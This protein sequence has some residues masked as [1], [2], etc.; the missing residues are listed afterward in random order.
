MFFVIVFPKVSEKMKGR[1][2]HETTKVA[3]QDKVKNTCNF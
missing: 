3:Y 1:L 2:G